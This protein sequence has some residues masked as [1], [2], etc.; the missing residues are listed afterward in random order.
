M[1]TCLPGILK[2]IRALRWLPRHRA[3][4]HRHPLP[5]VEV[6]LPSRTGQGAS[7]GGPIYLH[8]T[9]TIIP[10][11]RTY[12]FALAGTDFEFGGKTAMGIDRVLLA[13][14]YPM[15][16]LENACDSSRVSCLSG[17]QRKGLFPE[18]KARRD[19]RRTGCVSFS[20]YQK[21]SAG[22]CSTIQNPSP[23]PPPLPAKY[24]KS[25]H[26]SINYT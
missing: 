25:I 20:A 4:L 3:E 19:N 17:G 11:L 13:T 21:P 10:H 8:P 2:N 18:R 23:S 6:A 7:I 9:A 24:S 16:L 15:R 1:Q 5:R 22:I 12:G 14:D 26:I